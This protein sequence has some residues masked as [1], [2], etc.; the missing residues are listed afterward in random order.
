MLEVDNVLKEGV[1]RTINN[2]NKIRYDKIRRK[3][4]LTL[5]FEKYW[6]D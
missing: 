1:R 5:V 6:M 3:Y 2:I 4:L